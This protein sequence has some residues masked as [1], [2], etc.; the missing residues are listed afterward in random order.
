VPQ[1]HLCDVEK[2]H[3]GVQVHG[4]YAFTSGQ[5]QRLVLNRLEREL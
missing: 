4:T 3:E 5:A 1:H 2:T